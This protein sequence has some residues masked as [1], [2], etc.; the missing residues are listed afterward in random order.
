MNKRLAW[1]AKNSLILLKTGLPNE[2]GSCQVS[3]DI[4]EAMWVH[5]LHSTAA[6]VTFGG[7]ICQT[8]YTYTLCGPLG[9][10]PQHLGHFW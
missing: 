7:H 9:I 4:T 5:Y 1:T 6:F 3:L 8:P 10:L 2:I